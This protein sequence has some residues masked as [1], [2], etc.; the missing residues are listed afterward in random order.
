MNRLLPTLLKIAHRP[1][2]LLLAAACVGLGLF[3]LMALALALTSG[4]PIA[5][6]P[7]VIAAVLW[8]CVGTFAFYRAQL[9]R[10][11]QAIAHQADARV[12]VDQSVAAPT[13]STEGTVSSQLH[14]E[15]Q[16]LGE[17]YREST[18]RTARYFPRIEAAQRGLLQAAGGVANAPY[19]KYDL[20]LVLGAF[21]GTALALPAS[22]VGFIV[23]AFALLV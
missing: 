20:R 7:L 6:L 18:I 4:S 19:L 10:H 2:G 21:L 23:C 1:G 13:A 12:I 17:A 11:V 16:V 5:W 14:T 3:T 8:V 9:Q 22:I 15:A